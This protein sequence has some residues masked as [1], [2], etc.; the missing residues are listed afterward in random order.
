MSTCSGLSPAA[1]AFDGI[2]A[3]FD[4]RFGQWQSVAAQRRAVRDELARA[5]KPGS[6]VLEIGGGTGEDAMWLR[7]AGCEVVLTDVSPAMVRQAEAKF[8]R[9][10][11]LSA[12]VAGAEDLNGLEPG[13]DGAFSNFAALNCVE[14]LEPFARGLSRLVRPGGSV[15]LVL[16]GTCCAGEWI[17]EGLRRRPR[18]MF[19]RASR[20]PVEATLGGER[21]TVRYFRSV[22]V[23]AA[24][25]PWFDYAGRRGIGVFVPPSAAE[26]WISRHPRLLATAEA[27]DQR[28]SSP[29]A[30]LGDHILYRFQRRA[31]G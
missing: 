30:P 6:R 18:K 28:V 13:F 2:A 26:P 4:E 11:G 8:A 19:R 9:T 20:R 27:L 31:E 5:F 23:K 17:V 22:E 24:M 29:V 1:R 15:L 14:A 21:F 16:F 10:P 3:S 12:L 7:N 25:A